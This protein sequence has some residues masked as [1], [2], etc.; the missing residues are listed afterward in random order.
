VSKSEE[1]KSNLRPHVA[2]G[3][4]ECDNQLP[5]WWVG[6]FIFTIVFGIGYMI[7]FHLLGAPSL[8]D[9]FV[10]ATAA[11]EQSAPS[12]DQ[13]GSAGPAGSTVASLI[14]DEGAIA[15]GK[16]VYAT[17]CVACHAADGGG[18]VGPNLTDGYWIHGGNP[19]DIRATIATGIADKGMIGWLP[20]LG[21][22]KI[23]QLTAFV[24][25]LQGSS[26]ADP[27][28]PQGY[29]NGQEA[30][31]GPDGGAGAATNQAPSAP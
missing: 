16:Q 21:P 24:V 6:L 3:I 4:Q 14:G 17:N 12:M 1:N 5:L 23:D 22:T 27:K 8:Q 18:G 28:A 2:D 30:P 25:S 13:P 26:P 7:R 29:Q 10:N 19:E 9:E 11:R 15:E 31:P 20:I